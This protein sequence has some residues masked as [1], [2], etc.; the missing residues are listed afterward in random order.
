MR[1]NATYVL[2]DRLSSDPQFL[3]KKGENRTRRDIIT[4]DQIHKRVLQVGHFAPK[5]LVCAVL[6]LFCM[7]KSHESLDWDKLSG[8]W[9]ISS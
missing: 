8:S 7:S 6:N 5:K 2:R 4:N 3:Q 1:L 9:L